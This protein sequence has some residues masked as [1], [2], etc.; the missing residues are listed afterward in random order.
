MQINILEDTPEV[1]SHFVKLHGMLA[2]IE[3]LQ[4]TRSRDI[5]GILLRVVNLVSSPPCL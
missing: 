3:V 4:V 2:V 5:L 1:K